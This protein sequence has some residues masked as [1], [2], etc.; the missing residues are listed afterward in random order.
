M[1]PVMRIHPLRRAVGRVGLLLAV[2]AG[3][4]AAE[5]LASQKAAPPPPPAAPASLGWKFEE[6][7]R[8]PAPEAGQGVVVDADFFYALNNYTIAY[9]GP[10]R[11]LELPQSAP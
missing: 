7:R 4:P 6:L 11:L 10:I 8:Y 9:L 3:L 2:A 5:Q 1:N